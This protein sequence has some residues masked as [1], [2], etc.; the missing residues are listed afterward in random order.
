MQTSS[1]T[2]LKIYNLVALYIRNDI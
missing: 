1:S 2:P